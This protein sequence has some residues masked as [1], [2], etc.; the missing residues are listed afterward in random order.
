MCLESITELKPKS[1][2]FPWKIGCGL[3]GGDWKTYYSVI[4]EWSKKNPEIY[5]VFYKLD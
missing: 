2:G 1:I 3:A 5:C 4:L